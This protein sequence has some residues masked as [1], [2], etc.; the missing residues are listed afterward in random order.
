MA[1]TFSDI[2]SIIMEE[3]AHKGSAEASG[4]NKSKGAN[5]CTAKQEW[6]SKK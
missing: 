4:Q 3:I 6:L 2:H 5:N 1:E